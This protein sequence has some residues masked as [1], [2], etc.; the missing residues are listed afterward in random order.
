MAAFLPRIMVDFF[1]HILDEIWD[2]IHILWQACHW[3]RLDREHPNQ[4]DPKN[5][6]VERENMKA[7]KLVD[8]TY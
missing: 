3:G 8:K 6:R 5:T 1:V 2:C 4:E 7:C